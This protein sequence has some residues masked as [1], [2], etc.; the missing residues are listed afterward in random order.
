MPSLR[1]LAGYHRLPSAPMSLVDL[2]KYCDL[3]GPLL[4]DLPRSNSFHH[5]SR[6]AYV[7][8]LVSCKTTHM[9]LSLSLRSV[10]ISQSRFGLTIIIIFSTFILLLILVIIILIFI[11]LRGGHR[12]LSSSNQLSSVHHRRSPNMSPHPTLISSKPSTIFSYVKYDLMSMSNDETPTGKPVLSSSS[13]I[14]LT[15][16][17]QT[18][19][20]S[21]VG[22][23]ITTTGTNS[24]NNEL[25]PGTWNE[26]DAMLHCSASLSDENDDDDDEEQ[27]IISTD[28]DESHHHHH[29]HHGS[30]QMQAGP[31]TIIYV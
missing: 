5:R 11:L 7:T 17:E 29:H 13:Q 21:M 9:L 16:L 12:A 23:T 28:N 19:T 1:M 31:P 25:E 24:S 8:P 27:E 10:R 2:C 30:I 3:V 18:S 26:D 14:P 20:H 6:Q 22:T 15:S 4:S